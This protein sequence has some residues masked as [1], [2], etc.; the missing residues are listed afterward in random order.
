MARLG[1]GRYVAQGGDQGAGVTDNMGRQAPAGLLG[2]HMNLLVPALGGAPEPTNTDEERAAAAALATS[3]Q[4]ARLLP[5]AG[6]RRRR[7]SGAALLDYPSPGA[8]EAQPP[9]TRADNTTSM[10]RNPEACSES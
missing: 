10:G 7:P 2:I 9:K 1:Y 4:S 8:L 5:R 3:R 6:P